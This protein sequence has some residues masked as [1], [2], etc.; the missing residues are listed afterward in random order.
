VAVQS[1]SSGA[2][3]S[4]EHPTHGYLRLHG[5]LTNPDDVAYRY[6]LMSNR[7]D[8]IGPEITRLLGFTVEEMLAMDVAETAERIHIDDS[9]TVAP[10]VRTMLPDESTVLHYQFRAKDGCHHWLEDHYQIVA[11]AEERPRYRIGVMR[12][13]TAQK[14]RGELCYRLPSVRTACTAI[15]RALGN[16][17]SEPH[18]TALRRHGLKIAAIAIALVQLVAGAGL[19]RIAERVLSHTQT[20]SIQIANNAQETGGPSPHPPLQREVERLVTERDHLQQ[21]VAVLE[22]RMVQLS[23]EL[24]TVRSQRVAAAAPVISP[25]PAISSPWRVSHTPHPELSWVRM[26]GWFARSAVQPIA[27]DPPSWR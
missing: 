5:V 27:S 2:F 3:S 8:Y 24:R 11:D 26:R 25:Q 21:R 23:T 14:T 6:N 10:T 9:R 16:V 19:Y 18:R 12:G 7:F 15:P 4:D 22:Q 13:V 20:S 1:A 17:L